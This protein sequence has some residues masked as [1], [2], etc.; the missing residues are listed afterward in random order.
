LE[1]RLPGNGLE[2]VLLVILSDV[3]E[4]QHGRDYSKNYRSL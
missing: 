4:V 2:R 1:R 3:K